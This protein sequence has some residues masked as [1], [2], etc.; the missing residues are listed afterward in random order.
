MA[1]KTRQIKVG[2]VRVSF[3]G[4]SWNGQPSS[5]KEVA[6]ERI[7]TGTRAYAGQKFYHIKLDAGATANDRQRSNLRKA[8]VVK[9]IARF[10]AEGLV[11][12]VVCG[13]KE[14][15]LYR[16]ETSEGRIQLRGVCQGCAGSVAIEGQS[17]SLH[18]Y[19]RPGDGHVYGRCVGAHR[20]AANFSTELTESLIEELTE[21]AKTLWGLAKQS[22]ETGAQA[23]ATK[24]ATRLFERFQKQENE[25]D[26]KGGWTSEENRQAWLEAEK[27]QREHENT[28]RKRRSMA[29][30]NEVFAKHL[31]TNAL[32]A[33]GTKLEE[34]I[35]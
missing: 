15:R 25:Q 35:L 7:G 3:V 8:E 29:H 32:P 6:G 10:A 21:S 33:L 18:G 16:E 9:Q 27:V 26:A 12:K 23:K 2:E 14:L 13:G 20:T 5:E 31:T 28:N 17:T 11:A 30:N 34:V 1:V 24:A 4:Y 22:E 19:Q